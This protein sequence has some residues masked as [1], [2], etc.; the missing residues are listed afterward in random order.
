MKY[1]NLLV[2]T[3]NS[4]SNKGMVVEAGLLNRFLHKYAQDLGA[5]APEG[6][7]PG[8]ADP[9][10]EDSFATQDPMGGQLPP[11]GEMQ[12][13]MKE[14]TPELPQE[15][16]VSPERAKMQRTLYYRFEKWHDILD[17]ELPKYEYLEKHNIDAIRSSLS[18]VHRAFQQ[19]VSNRTQDFDREQVNEWNDQMNRLVDRMHEVQGT[20][21]DRTRAIVDAY[22]LYGTTNRLF[23]DFKRI[24]G[25]DTTYANVLKEFGDL[26]RVF[27]QVIKQVP[28]QVAGEDLTR[29][30]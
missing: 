23:E 9:L 2:S 28:E 6:V 21:L 1:L 20:K 3:I 5:P 17:N 12:Q 14:P 24:A 8:E 27:S 4:L 26:M 10:Q 15:E 22:M 13:P 11:Q 19:A 18:A 25:H 30:R 29:I 7:P 16:E